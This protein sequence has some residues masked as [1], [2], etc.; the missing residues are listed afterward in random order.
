MYNNNQMMYDVEFVQC[1]QV[2]SS[3]P[4]NDEFSKVLLKRS[5]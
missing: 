2:S 1:L 5:F 4:G 3:V